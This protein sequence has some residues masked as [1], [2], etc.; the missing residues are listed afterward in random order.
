[1]GELWSCVLLRVRESM[2]PPGRLPRPHDQFIDPTSP[3]PAPVAPEHHVKP[4]HLGLPSISRLVICRQVRTMRITLLLLSLVLCASH[5]TAS[6]SFWARQQT[7]E[8]TCEHCV[9]G[10]GLLDKALSSV[11]LDALV[12]VHAGSCCWPPH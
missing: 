1:M 6:A 3:Q 9:R 12:S 4:R 11:N 10:V 5:R 7:R 8:E 2:A